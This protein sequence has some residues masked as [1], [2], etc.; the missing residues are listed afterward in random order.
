MIKK[1]LFFVAIGM[2]LSFATLEKQNNDNNYCQKLWIEQKNNF[3]KALIHFENSLDNPQD[4]SKTH[5]AFLELR[6]A[7]KRWEPLASYYFPAWASE[8]NGAP[9]PKVDEND[10][11]W[12][13]QIAPQ[14]LQVIEDLL[15]KNRLDST[16]LNTI[17]SLCTGL[18][19][20]I[21]KV[22]KIENL[23]RF[24]KWQV[25]DAVAIEL[26]RIQ[27]LGL[28]GFDTPKS[29]QNLLESATALGSSIELVQKIALNSPN[30]ERQQLLSWSKKAQQAILPLQ[31]HNP[32]SFDKITWIR[33]QLSPLYSEIRNWQWQAERNALGHQGRARP[34]AINPL[35][36]NLFDKNFFNIDAFWKGPKPSDSISA[37]LLGKML[38]N[39]KS[40][41]SN[42]SLSC[43][44]CHLEEMGFA[45]GKAKSIGQNGEILE[46]NSPGLKGAFWQKSFF[47]DGR[48]KGLNEQ[49]DHVVF[50]HGEFNTDYMKMIQAIQK[51][52]YDSLIQRSF[53]QSK[54]IIAK[55]VINS[56]I[57]WYIYSLGV[58]NNS[59]AR[60]M[61]QETTQLPAA[62][63][64]GAN[65]FM[66]KALC[67]TCHFAPLWSGL[68]APMYEE[69]EFEVIGTPREPD[70][71]NPKPDLDLGRGAKMKS[72]IWQGAFK[73]PSLINVS[74]TAPYMHHGSFNKLEEV[75]ELY[76]KGG[77]RGLG[78]DVPNQTLPFD[79]LELSEQDQ[80]D[81]VAF[82]G[83][84][85][86]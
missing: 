55:G 3:T 17:K 70:F 24:E 46:R 75:I 59:F 67:A 50:S 49:M 26:I 39:D 57:A 21:S 27:T 52:A 33:N 41:S 60:W 29:G 84:L 6:Q 72:P 4:Q 36:G 82:L 30:P 1:I 58:G 7:W 19:W 48:A 66:G 22:G 71:V 14:G 83:A 51:P 79:H 10:G 35:A 68:A 20:S 23:A 32:D 45:D 56:A 65:L 8:I 16:Q 53:P 37:V 34:S 18:H 69:N 77:G 78:L 13:T 43:A 61:R 31:I 5:S 15:W 40:L 47:W 74:K 42:Q 63:H 86:E 25:L 85:A 62:V 76:H 9:I 11:S 73:T 28:S 54:G 81:L 64:R 38:F 80:S 44:S 12:Q 2:L